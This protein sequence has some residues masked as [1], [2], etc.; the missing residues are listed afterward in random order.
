MGT[1]NNEL[2]R[3]KRTGVSNGDINNDF[4]SPRLTLSPAQSA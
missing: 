1:S 3:R 4:L 2:L